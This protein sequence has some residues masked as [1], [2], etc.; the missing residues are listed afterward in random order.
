MSTTTT[1]LGLTKPEVLDDIKLNTIPNIANN[2]QKIDDQIGNLSGL[3]GVDIRNF[4][5]V[6]DGVNDD[7]V[8]IQNAV[9][10]ATGLIQQKSSSTDVF[11]GQVKIVLPAKKIYIKSKIN[12]PNAIDIEGQGTATTLVLMANLDYIFDFNNNL[13]GAVT[14]N[15]ESQMEGGSLRNLRISGNKRGYTLTSAVRLYNVDHFVMDSV[16]FYAVKGKCIEL[17]T[18][19]E[20]NFNNIFTRFCG[21]TSQGNIEIVAEDTG[22]D[23]SNLNLGL[24][25]SIIFPYGPALKIVNT[26]AGDNNFSNINGLWVHGIFSTIKGNLVSYFGVDEYN[27]SGSNQIDITNGEIRVTGGNFVYAPNLNSYIKLNNSTFY[28]ANSKMNGHYTANETHGSGDYF[29]YLSNSSVLYL[30]SGVKAQSAFQNTDIFFADGTSA[31]YGSLEDLNPAQWLNAPVSKKVVAS[32][33]DLISDVTSPV[34][35]RPRATQS[36]TLVTNVGRIM[37]DIRTALDLDTSILQLGV[38]QGITHPLA[39]LP[40]GVMF[41][42]PVCVTS[43]IPK[44]NGMMWIDSVDGSVKMYING[45]QKTVTLT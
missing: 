19:R 20:C 22:S 4:G 42:L 11:A 12:V 1:N 35:F 28:I 21:T 9:N 31:I 16:Y 25:W 45:V 13:A 32:E 7:A 14:K 6:G 40:D 36:S 10:Y 3:V 26:R 23:T 8:S 37:Y 5:Y 30:E 24:N 29:F 18:A 38:D 33:I 2:F 17:N 43:T 34:T 44:I 39:A 27:A 15:E 41:K